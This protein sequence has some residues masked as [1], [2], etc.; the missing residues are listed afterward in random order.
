MPDKTLEERNCSIYFKWNNTLDVWNGYLVKEDNSVKEFSKG[1]PNFIKCFVYNTKNE[2][3]KAATK[4][5]DNN[6]R[7][8][9]NYRG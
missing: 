4:W 6:Y 7:K 8:L 3:I 9:N 2:C 5:A 1:I